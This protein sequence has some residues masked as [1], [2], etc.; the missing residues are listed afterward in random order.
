MLLLESCSKIFQ[1]STRHD[2]YPQNKRKTKETCYI[3]VIY[4][5]YGGKQNPETTDPNSIKSES[6]VD[7]EKDKALS[8]LAQKRSLHH[9]TKGPK[10]T[11]TICMCIC[12]KK[13]KQ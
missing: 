1:F 7:Q 3:I 2:C 10:D 11:T 4:P 12:L 8:K 13:K 5:S 6:T 9:C